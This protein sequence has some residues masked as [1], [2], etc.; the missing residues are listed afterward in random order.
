METLQ[1][2]ETMPATLLAFDRDRALATI[3]CSVEP[4]ASISLLPNEFVDAAP[5]ACALRETVERVTREPEAPCALLELLA[6]RPSR[7]RVATGHVELAAASAAGDPLDASEAAIDL[8]TRLDDSY[9]CVQGPPGTG[10][11]HTAARAIVELVGAG[12]RVG[13]MAVSHRAISNLLERALSMLSEANYRVDAVKVQT[14]PSSAGQAPAVSPAAILAPVP[15]L[16][17]FADCSCAHTDH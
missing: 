6:R 14:T 5:I 7:L 9:L 8:V 1:M 2:M 15:V 4:V 13:V 12:E 10:K 11:T 3:E 17:C 16:A